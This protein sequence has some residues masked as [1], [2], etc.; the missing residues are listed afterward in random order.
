[1]LA[2]CVGLFAEGTVRVRQAL[3]PLE[4]GDTA[5]ESGIPPSFPIHNPQDALKLLPIQ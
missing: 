4:E 2:W 5:N 3:R 1:M